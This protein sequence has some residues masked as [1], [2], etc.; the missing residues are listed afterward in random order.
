MKTEGYVFGN[1]IVVSSSLFLF[2][3]NVQ[4]IGD[5]ETLNFGA[6]MIAQAK[7]VKRHGL[8]LPSLISYHLARYKEAS[9]ASSS[10]VSQRKR[11][12]DGGIHTT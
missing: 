1:L 5:W 10:V 7:K 9:C 12:S 2:L 11:K 8:K 6:S 4:D 3:T